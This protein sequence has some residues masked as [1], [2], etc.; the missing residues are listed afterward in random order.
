MV[1]LLQILQNIQKKILKII[2]VAKNQSN[3]NEIFFDNF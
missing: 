3:F 1:E 2:F